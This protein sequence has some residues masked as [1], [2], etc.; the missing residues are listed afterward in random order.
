MK[1]IIDFLF[2]MSNKFINNIILKFILQKN[3][4]INHKKLDKLLS[5]E[6]IKLYL[7][8]LLEYYQSY[9]E[10]IYRI[11]YHEEKQHYCPVCGKPL[12]YY[13]QH[14]WAH[15]C[16]VKCSSLDKNV[17]QKVKQTCLR[18]YG[19]DSIAKLETNCFKTNNPSKNKESREKAKQ[20]CLKKYGCE[21]AWNNDTQKQT[22]LEKYG[23]DN[24]RKSE[25]CK[26]KIKQTCLEKYGDEH[27]NNREKYKQTC[28]ENFGVDN[29]IK[30]KEVLDKINWETRNE[31]SYKTKLQ[32]NTFNTSTPED[33]SYELLKEKYLYVI[34]QYRSKVYP[35]NCDFYIPHLDLYIE[36]NYSQFHC[37]H[38]FD[39]TNIKDINKLNELI[40]KDKKSKRNLIG[41]ESQYYR[42]IYV[43][44][45][46]DVRKRN[47]AKENNL[48]YIEFW[49]IEELKNWLN[50]NGDT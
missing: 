15:H 3:N 11:L 45:D 30:S 28:L 41:K 48:N 49:N 37:K 44:T 47:I 5:Y 31:K 13:G 34:R 38:K 9:N 16:S 33:Q 36:C 20:T 43:W 8:N 26:Q 46:L 19:A 7:E 4:K 17:Q 1:T 12:K 10:I 2:N 23:V 29:P 27:Y 22:C 21:Y 39:P 6:N 35:F 50:K 25:Y 14:S 18:K 24:I 32:N 42:M 40:E